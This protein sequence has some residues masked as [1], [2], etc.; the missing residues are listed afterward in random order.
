[1]HLGDEVLEHL[2]GYFKIGDDTVFERPYRCNISRGLAEHGLGLFSYRQHPFAAAIFLY[3]NDRRFV[4][5]YSFAF[6]VDERAC[7]AEVY[8]KI[9]RENSE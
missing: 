2:F 8:S 6:N 9:V 1:M 7:R 4:R 5:D 3:G